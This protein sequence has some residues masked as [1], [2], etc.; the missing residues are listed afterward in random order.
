MQA[1]E[2][3]SEAN[4]FSLLNACTWICTLY[5]WLILVKFLTCKLH[6]RIRGFQLFAYFQAYMC[7]VRAIG[8]IISLCLN[9]DGY[10]AFLIKLTAKRNGW[11]S[12]PN[13]RL[14]CLQRNNILCKELDL[15]TTQSVERRERVIKTRAFILLNSWNV[16]RKPWSSP[17]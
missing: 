10:A 6:W 16:R 14:I 9:W 17:I 4:S 12:S 13:F 11:F 5:R 8:D 7:A 3:E 15:F 1:L 2:H